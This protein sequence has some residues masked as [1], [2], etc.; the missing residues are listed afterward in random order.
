MMYV[1]GVMKR[2][3]ENNCEECK[4]RF[5]VIQKTTELSVEIEAGMDSGEEIIFYGEGDATEA[6]RAGDLIFVLQT[7]KHRK[8]ERIQK[9]DL[10]MKMK[11][12]LKE[13]LVG[14]S[15]TI[16][17]LDGRKLELKSEQILKHGDIMKVHNEGMPGRHGGKKGD[18]YIEFSIVYPTSLT[19]EQ[20]ELVTKALP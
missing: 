7:I 13:A 11:I 18:L 1:N 10:K 19:A 6:T 4:N 9:N 14:F 20:K 17:H 12:S 8:F 3:V 5:D 16:T 15:K 2:I